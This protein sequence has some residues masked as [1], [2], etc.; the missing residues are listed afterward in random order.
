MTTIEVSE[1]ATLAVPIDRVWEVVSNTA[2]YADWV[3]GVVEVTDDHGP[4][5]VGRT[6]SEVNKSVGPLT[7]RTTWT[8]REV[9]PQ[10]TR[11]D[12]GVG[13][14]P[15]Q[16]FVN[17]FDFRANRDGGTEMTYTARYSVGLGPVGVILERLL[18]PGMRHGF[19]TSMRN[20]EDLITAEG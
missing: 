4:A 8:V 7:M 17:V 3:H 1:T 10:R 16:N 6:Y 2:R 11:V 19:Q 20:L 15:L 18:R 5:T 14:A 9:D 13:L 12:T